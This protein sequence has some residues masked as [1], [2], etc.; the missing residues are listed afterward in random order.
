MLLVGLGCLVPPPRP[1]RARLARGAMWRTSWLSREVIVLPAFIARRRAVV[2]WRCGWAPRRRGCD[3]R[4]RVVALGLAAL[5]WLCTAMIYACLRFI[6]EW[7]HPL[8][9]VNFV[10]S[11]CPRASCSCCRSAP[12]PAKASWRAGAVRPRVAGDHPRRRR[13][14]RWRCAATR[15]SVT[16]R[17]CSRPPASPRRGWCRRRWACRPARSTRASSSIAPRPWGCGVRGRCSSSSASRCRRSWPRSA[18]PRRRLGPGWPLQCLQVPGL[19]A[20]RW[21][22]F[23]QAKHPQ[24][25]YYQ[26]VS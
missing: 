17:R 20:E 18:S 12:W 2:G 24:N 25:L 14:H 1:P 10:L 19:V 8:T 21:F 22:F 7:A 4:C 23:A 3:S 9:L 26:V 15:A 16:A 5:L 13:A 6:Q 11:A